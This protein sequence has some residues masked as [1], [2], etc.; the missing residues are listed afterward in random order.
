MKKSLLCIANVAIAL[1]FSINAMAASGK[2]A[3]FDNSAFK[4]TLGEGHQWK[5]GKFEKP[6]HMTVK[7]NGLTLGPTDGYSFV[8]GPDNTQWYAIQSFEENNYYYTASTITLYNSKGEQ[9]GVINV[10]IPEGQKVNQI[11]VGDAITLTLFDRDKNTYEL[12][13]MVHAIIEAGVTKNTTYVYDVTSGELKYTYDGFMALVDYNTG[14]STDWIGV[15]SNDTIVNDTASV[16]YDVYN[17]ATWSSN[18]ASL[19][20]SFIIPKSLAEY[21]VGGVFNVFEV[22]NSMYYVVSAYEKPFL[23]PASYEEPWDMIPTADNNFIATIY[24]KNFVEVGKVK[25]PVTSTSKYL[26]QYGVGLYGSEDLSNDFWD[27]SGALRLV[28]ATTGF[29]VTSEA[30][31]ISFDVYDLESN[32]VKTIAENVSDWMKM[33][34]VPGHSQQMAFLLTD[35][36]TLN[37]VNVPS[38]ETAVSFGS[39]VEGEAIS[40]NI[41][42]Y[43]VGDSYQYVIGLPSPETDSENNYYQRF[44]WVTK[45]AKIDHIVK[46]NLGK[47]NASWVPLVMG[48]TLNPYLFDTDDQHEY[49]FI[50]NQ[51]ASG[52]SGQMYDELRIM[53]EDGT[54]VKIYKEDGTNGDLGTCDIL[55]LNSDYPSLIIPFLNSTTDKITLEIEPLPF[56]MFS[57]GGEGTAENPY[58]IA[59]AGDMAMIARDPAAHYKVV[60]DF[61]ATQYGLWAPIASFTGTLDGGNFTISDLTLDGS[62]FEAGIFAA[63]ENATIKDLKINDASV[64]VSN[65]TTVAILVGEA[66]TTTISNVH[67]NNATITA[68]ADASATIGTIASGS[69]LNSVISECSATNLT[70]DAP[71]CSNVGGI[72]GASRTGTSISACAVNGTINADNNIGGIAGSTGADCIV[73]NC[74]VD[75]DITG[76]NTIGGIV[77]SAD[78]GGI[79]LC[80]AEGTLTATEGD[81]SGNYKVGGIAGYL[82]TAWSDPDEETIA[83]DPWKGFVISNNVVAISEIKSE[84]GAVHRV[85]GYSRWE[86]DLDAAKYDT[87]IVPTAEAWIKENYVVSTLGVVDNTIEAANTTTEGASVEASALNKEYF[88]GLGFAYGTSVDAPWAEKENGVILYFETSNVDGVESII[89]EKV[90]IN[91]ANGIISADEAVAIEVYNLSGTKIASGCATIDA[92]NLQKGIYVVVAIDATGAKKT[93]KIAVK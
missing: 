10:T 78:R 2:I 49:V 3:T 67:I 88:T 9:Q 25:I 48:E 39:S 79:H 11:L 26:V 22:D 86:E 92:S 32:K 65:A 45:D 54:E 7:A 80:Y 55:G 24:N 19:K 30:E 34:D 16:K 71:S 72:I 84:S 14:Y 17:K 20:K 75:A 64:E 59:S 66:N 31:A 40:T 36:A 38:C 50:A 35:D 21:Q 42:R 81:W 82:T 33:Y 62:N 61:S 1:I 89:T 90:E 29:D 12:P 91:Y 69:S 93:A 70:I 57:K 6:E 53:K 15:V 37:M 87:S 73:L 44:A 8:K 68:T 43:P 28:V 27:E 77:G 4:A 83:A 52:T 85:V 58:L 56:A 47:S 74:H 18:G 41:D 23:D 46:F 51:F 5:T 63:S 60:N 13:V 76:K